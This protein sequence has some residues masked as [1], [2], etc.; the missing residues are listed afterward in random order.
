MGNIIANSGCTVDI[1]DYNETQQDEATSRCL[2]AHEEGLVEWEGRG[3]IAG[4][5]CKAYYMTTEGDSKYA[6][7]TEDWGGIDWLVRL[8][9]VEIITDDGVE[10]A[11]IYNPKYSAEDVTNYWIADT[12]NG[13]FD[14]PY[15]S[16][17]EA[18]D[19]LAFWIADGI[20]K[21]KEVQDEAGLTDVEIEERVRNFYSIETK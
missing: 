18:E 9:R 12:N 20:E 10:V 15:S 8:H 7:E 13:C 1:T 4:L 11:R 6:E 16:I 5:P 19:R 3:T 14:G 21:E 2:E 17:V